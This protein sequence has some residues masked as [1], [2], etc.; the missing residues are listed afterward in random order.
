MKKS[1]N[2][3]VGAAPGTQID[4]NN[5]VIIDNKSCVSGGWKEEMANQRC[6]DLLWWMLGRV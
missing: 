2:G 1:E 6:I 3:A 4:N 5:G